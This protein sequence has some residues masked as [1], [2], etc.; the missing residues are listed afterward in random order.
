MFPT[1]LLFHATDFTEG[2]GEGG[3]GVYKVSMK[4]KTQQGDSGLS[5]TSIF[6]RRIIGPAS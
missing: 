4:V 2:L 3:L 5:R 6:H 1:S